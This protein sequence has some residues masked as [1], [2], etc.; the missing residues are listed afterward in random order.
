M[1]E[2]E[3]FGNFE[4]VRLERLGGEKVDLAEA[5]Y[6]QEPS[7]EFFRPR[8]FNAKRKEGKS[9]PFL[10]REQSTENITIPIDFDKVSQKHSPGVHEAT[11]RN[12]RDSEKDREAGDLNYLDTVA[13]GEAFKSFSSEDCNKEHSVTVDPEIIESVR[14]QLSESDLNEIDKEFFGKGVNVDDINSCDTDQSEPKFVENLPLCDTESH[15]VN[16]ERRGDSGLSRDAQ[17]DLNYIDEQFFSVPSPSPQTEPPSLHE[18]VTIA[19]F[20]ETPTEN[21]TDAKNSKEGKKKNKSKK[22]N[23]HE[24]PPENQID[25]E[26]MQEGKKKAKSKKEKK[27]KE[28]NQP[29]SSPAM[30][31]VRKLR[32]APTSDQQSKD[33]SDQIGVNLLRG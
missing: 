22:E 31:Y 13:F 18:P 6:E 30:D 7:R 19:P 12:L 25:S 20:N 2:K 23:V 3:E 1:G 29:E 17:S 10:I 28:K 14:K 21:K 11:N 16:N 4:H 5:L 15:E 24:T 32:K 9:S 27:V 33:P 8:E 26:N